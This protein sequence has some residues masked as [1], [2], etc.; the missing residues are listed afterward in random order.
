LSNFTFVGFLG[1][2]VVVSVLNFLGHY[3][4]QCITTKQLW[5][6]T[7]LFQSNTCGICLFLAPHRENLIYSSDIHIYNEIK[8]HT[9]WSGKLEFP[10]V[11]VRHETKMEK[12][13]ILKL[14][15][16]SYTLMKYWVYIQ[17]ISLYSSYCKATS[18]I[19]FYFIDVLIELI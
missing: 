8:S 16:F 12:T 17:S 5:I 11:V 19:I 15:Y 1:I 6:H 14:D 18:A 10:L 7:K 4:Q 3:M 9:L 2:F 13:L